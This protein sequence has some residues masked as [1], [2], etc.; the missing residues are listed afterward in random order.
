MERRLKK[1]FAPFSRSRGDGVTNSSGSRSSESND[2]NSTGTSNSISPSDDTSTST[3]TSASISYSFNGITAGDGSSEGTLLQAIQDFC[4]SG[5]PGS[6]NQGEEF[7][8]LPTIVEI[9]E[10]T[11]SSAALAA[12][13]ILNNLDIS[14]ISRP[15]IQYNSIMLIRILSQNP[16]HSFTRNLGGSDWVHNIKELLRNGKDQSVHTILCETLEHFARDPARIADEEL[17][18]LRGFWEREKAANPPRSSRSHR[19]QHHHQQ[20]HHQQHHYPQHQ[21]HQHHHQQYHHQQYRQQRPP[22]VPVHSRP[23]P[24]LPNPAEL[25]ARIAEANNSANLLMQLVQS[26]PR[27]EILR[28]DLIREFAER[29]KL[30]YKSIRGFIN[31]DPQPDADTLITLIETNDNLA[32]SLKAHKHAVARALEQGNLVRQDARLSDIREMPFVAPSVTMSG[33]LSPPISIE[34]NQPQQNHGNSNG[35]AAQNSGSE[36]GPVSPVTPIR[37]QSNVFRGFGR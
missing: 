25:S 36:S 1:V 37:E 12:V 15:Y 30:A 26:T 7:L 6:Q 35:P 27:G 5:K 21:P 8:Y 33:A 18:R 11:P 9:A 19:D 28:H 16:G 3:H 24:V 29:C 22:H 20:H 10:S 23:H 14:N 4:E 32:M 34:T 13:A 31:A 17:D 2:S